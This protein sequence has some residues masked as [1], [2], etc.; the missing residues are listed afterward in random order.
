MNS[1]IIHGD[2][3]HSK[4]LRELETMR[5]GY[6][7][8][9]EGKS[10]GIFRQVPERYA[11]LPLVDYSSCLVIPGLTDLHVHAPQ[12][13][14][15]GLGMDLEL[16]DWLAARTFPEEARYSDMEYARAAYTAFVGELSK[17][18]TT[19]ASVFAT[20]HLPATGMLMDM[21]EQSGL[22]TMVGKVNMDRGGIDGLQEESA[23]ASVRDTVAWLESCAGRYR[24]ISPIL[25][26]RFIPS[27]T[28]GLLEGL[29]ELRREYRLPVQSHLAENRDEVALVAELCPLA[30]SYA[31]AYDRF[32]LFDGP[33]PTVMAHCVWLSGEEMALMGRK[34]VYVAHC[35]GSNMNLSSGIAPVRRFLDAGLNVG[36]G[37]DVAGG[38]HTSVFRA[39]SD[40]VQVSKLHSCLVN[41][42]EA[43][44]TMTEAFYLGTAGGG[45]F[46]GKVG[47]FDRDYEFDALVIDDSALNEAPRLSIPDRVA[48]MVYLSDDRHIR[49]KYVRGLKVPSYSDHSAGRP[50]CSQIGSIPVA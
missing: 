14:F 30:A 13:S 5:N 46:F 35:P 42:E 17:G 50:D 28:D 19:R 20:P 41:S 36:L 12:F 16:L 44:L 7:I 18:A 22:V 8:C 21:L 27:C 2:I 34:G 23:A 48:R 15:R 32:G 6:L 1:F 26:P 45:S 4:S 10:A 33:S 49:A 38:C 40:A 11:G 24:N 43:P 3:C 37:S 9:V 47:R 25:T 29:G 39:M 31:D